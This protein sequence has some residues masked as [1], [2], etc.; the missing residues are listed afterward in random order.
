MTRWRP[1]HFIRTALDAVKGTADVYLAQITVHGSMV[2][3]SVG[4]DMDNS[5]FPL[6][7]TLDIEQ[8]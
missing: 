6:Q 2:Y 8:P 4:D 3:H 1:L 7:P 5:L